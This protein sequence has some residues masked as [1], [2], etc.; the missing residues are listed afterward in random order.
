MSPGNDSPSGGKHTFFKRIYK[1]AAKIKIYPPQD[2]PGLAA[3]SGQA[4]SRQ[5]LLEQ[6]GSTTVRDCIF[7]FWLAWL[8]GWSGWLAAPPAP[9]QTN[10]EMVPPEAPGAAS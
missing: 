6:L 7:I 4:W 5:R 2:W 1:T 8:A 3:W 10:P 9:L